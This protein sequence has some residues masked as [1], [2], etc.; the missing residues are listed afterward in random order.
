M[1]Q[2][3]EPRVAAGELS[4][5]GDFLR[6]W[7]CAT[8][9]SHGSARLEARTAWRKR[10]GPLHR[11]YRDYLD[12]VPN[13]NELWE[14]WTYDANLHVSLGKA[15]ATDRRWL[16]GVSM[17]LGAVNLFDK[18]LPFSFSGSDT[19]WPNTISAG[20]ICTFTSMRDFKKIA[21]MW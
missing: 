9:E 11:A 15:V 10:I 7:L 16:S 14:F 3:L 13:T 17:E 18:R 4:Q 8:L 1:A 5:S 6:S 2:R 21:V 12:Y 19:T 20:D